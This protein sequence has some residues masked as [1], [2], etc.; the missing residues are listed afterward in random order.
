MRW[1]NPPSPSYNRSGT[2][3]RPKKWASELEPLR[4]RPGKWALIGTYPT[5]RQA[6]STARYCVR[7]SGV[8]PGQYEAVSRGSEVYARYLG[9]NNG[10]RK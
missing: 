4:K 8:K 3:G 6:Q 5:E 10:R 1:K 7:A 9:S 2:G